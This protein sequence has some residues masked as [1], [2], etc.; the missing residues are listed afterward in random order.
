MSE[1]EQERQAIIKWSTNRRVHDW[2]TLFCMVLFFA[3]GA[4]LALLH[5]SPLLA[6]W[7]TAAMVASGWAANR[8][9]KH[10]VTADLRLKQLRDHQRLHAELDQAFEKIMEQ[11]GFHRKRRAA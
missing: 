10:V 3:A 1:A 4:E 7:A 2:L 11:P 5:D 6:A 9:H 8:M